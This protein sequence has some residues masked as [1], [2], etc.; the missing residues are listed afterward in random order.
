MNDINTLINRVL[1]GDSYAAAKII[2]NVEN[3]KHTEEIIERLYPYRENSYLLGITGAPGV[4]KSTLT[5]KLIKQL[6]KD[7]K[8]VGVIAVDP[9]SPFTGG[10]L[11]G[12]RV[13]LQKHATDDKVF[14]RSMGSRNH[15]GGL[16]PGISNVITILSAL[17]CSYI[18]L[19][20]VGVGQSEIEVV[21]HADTVAL[22]LTPN[23]GDDVQ[24]MKAGIIEIADIFVLNKSDMPGKDKILAELR[25]FQTLSESNKGYIPPIVQTVASQDVGVSKLYQAIKNHQIFLKQSGKLIQKRKIRIEHEVIG[26]IQEK[27]LLHTKNKLA[28]DQELIRIVDSIY[29]NQADPYSIANKVLKNYLPS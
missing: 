23:S 10:A 22:V 25:F 5:D 16:A 21:E 7:D 3:D 11:L 24:I 14:I 26:I 19:E 9:T 1:N 27:L 15:L 13:R 18:I 17:G 12:D 2:T 29:K 8:R 4:G 20:T 6:R 28:S